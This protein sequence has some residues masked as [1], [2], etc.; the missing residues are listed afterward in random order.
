MKKSVW[1]LTVRGEFS[2]AH[3]LR[4]YQGKC[5]ARHGHSYQVEM[6]V[7][8]KVLTPDTE[9]VMD[10]DELKKLLRTEL[11]K[12]DHCDLNQVA[13]F[14]QINP[15]SENLARYLWKQLEAQL[16]GQPVQLHSVSVSEK[17]TQTATYLEID[18]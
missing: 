9:L 8:G 6:V 16:S 3:A 5:E 10:F 13:P 12:L 1:H 17:T 4:N 11:E 7:S 14:T 2:S 15:S 18:D